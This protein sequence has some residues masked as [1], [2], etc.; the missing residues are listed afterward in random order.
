M[1]AEFIFFRDSVSLELAKKQGIHSPVLEFGPDGAF[2]CDLRNDKEAKTFLK[3][4]GLEEG[5]FL[6][7]L[8][9]LR[10]TPYWTIPN[11]RRQKNKLI[12]LMEE[13]EL[14]C[15]PPQ[16]T[17]RLLDTFVGEFLEAN[18]VNPTFI[19]EQPEVMSPLA[20]YHR[21]K[22]LLTERFELFVCGREVRTECLP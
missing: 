9:R 7:C 20:K 19:T 5:K 8:S 16:S 2:A 14:E 12:K 13:H 17:A 1:A 21:S 15:A 18:I 6:C 10:Y 3:A 4:S 11:G 22:R